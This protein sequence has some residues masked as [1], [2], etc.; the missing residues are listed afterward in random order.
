MRRIIIVE[1]VGT[2][3]VYG[4]V[5]HRDM[6]MIFFSSIQSFPLQEEK[7]TPND[8]DRFKFLFYFLFLI[9]FLFVS[10]LLD[11]RVQAIYYTQ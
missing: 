8:H 9:K 10:V 1:D 11:Q 6:T 7:V 2:I 3:I 5:T 4:F